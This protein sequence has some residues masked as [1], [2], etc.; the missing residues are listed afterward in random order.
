MRINN[1]EDT[2][3]NRNPT[4]K[5]NDLTKNSDEYKLAEAIE[6]D[7]INKFTLKEWLEIVDVAYKNE[8]NKS[9]AIFF[10]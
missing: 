10:L 5:V 2:L 7:D 6:N 8:K 9:N 4:I 1:L 3:F